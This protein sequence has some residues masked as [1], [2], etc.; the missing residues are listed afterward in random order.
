MT[1]DE[2]EAIDEVVV[3]RIGGEKEEQ[4]GEEQSDDKNDTAEDLE[5]GVDIIALQVTY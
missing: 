3:G 5:E 1:E 4:E 2:E